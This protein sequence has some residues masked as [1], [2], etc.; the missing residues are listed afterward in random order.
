MA[1]KNYESPKMAEVKVETE[2][3]LETISGSGGGSQCTPVLED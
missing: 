1:K 3:L 2:S